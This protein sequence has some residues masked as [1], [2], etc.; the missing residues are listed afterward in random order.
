MALSQQE[1]DKINAGSAST[2][3]ANNAISV[4]DLNKTQT[5]MNFVQPNPTPVP[6]VTPPAPMTTPELQ[7]QTTTTSLQDLNNQL[8]GQSQYRTQQEQTQ[9][10]PELVKQQNELASRVTALSNEAN[11]IPLQ[12]QQE[13]LGRGITAGGLQPLQT[14]ALRNN[15]IQSLSASSLLEASRGNLA[16]AQNLVDRAVSARFD[17]IKEQIAVTQANLDLILKSPE[18]SLADKNRAQ[19]QKDI[20]DAKA[21][22]VAKQADDSK[23]VYTTALTAQKYGAPMDLVQKIQQAKTPDE[24]NLLASQYLTDPKAKYDL[25]AARLDNVYKQAQIDYQKAQ[26]AALGKPT[27]ADKRA[28]AADAKTAAAEAKA[29]ETEK[30][31]GLS[32]IPVLQDKVN[33]IDGLLSSDG[34]NTAVGTFGISRAIP[35]IDMFS[36]S[37]RT[38]FIAGVQQ[39]TSKETLDALTSLKAQGGTL[40]ALSDGERAM[41]EGS[42]TKIGTWALKDDTGKV[43]GYETSEDNFKKELNTIKTLTNRAILKAQ[44]SVFDSSEKSTLDSVFNDPALYNQTLTDP[45]MYFK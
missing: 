8:L 17:P 38:D 24:A 16:T 26:Q 40:G 11:A 31:A 9:N 25:E 42:A 37:A 3:S 23:A 34:L 6:V 19:A 4:A 10:I 33:L 43:Y 2:A 13:S 15:A 20:Q 44:G 18:Y 39:L 1:I 45:S 7:A 27:V 32:K 5:P 12:L 14:A 28:A 22:Q 35:I 30:Q 36:K 21:T 41:L 29:A